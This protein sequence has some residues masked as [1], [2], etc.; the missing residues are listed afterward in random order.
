[1]A[2]KLDLAKA[3]NHVD[4]DFLHAVLHKLGFDQKWCQWVMDCVPTVTY[5]VMVNGEPSQ[6]FTPN[7]GLWEGDL[8]SPYVFLFIQEAF[9]R[10]ILKA[11]AERLITGIKPKKALSFDISFAIC[12]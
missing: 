4:W 12:K 7:K 8:F 10:L 9:S 6:A 3:Y 11:M 5:K 1:M 2:L